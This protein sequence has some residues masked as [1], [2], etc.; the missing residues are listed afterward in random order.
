M[1]PL[2]RERGMVIADH[3]V[4]DDNKNADIFVKVIVWVKQQSNVLIQKAHIS[5]IT[6]PQTLPQI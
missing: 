4:A 3:K 2:E 5:T 1:V 6:P